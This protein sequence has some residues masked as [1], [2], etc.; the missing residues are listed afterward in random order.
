MQAV[1]ASDLGNLRS[2]ASDHRHSPQSGWWVSVLQGGT[3]E[4]KHA[5]ANIPWSVPRPLAP[6]KWSQEEGASPGP[7]EWPW[8]S[9]T[10]LVC[11]PRPSTSHSF[12]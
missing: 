11:V 12:A 3:W 2:S 5:L 9:Q 1:R 4:G 10:G 8:G 7:H 6:L